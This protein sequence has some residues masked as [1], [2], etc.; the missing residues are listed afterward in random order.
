MIIGPASAS[1]RRSLLQ[2]HSFLFGIPS[3]AT[4]QS[5]FRWL[6][7]LRATQ[8]AGSCR[9]RG[10][11]SDEQTPWNEP[12]K[13]TALQTSNEY[14]KAADLFGSVEDPFESTWLFKAEEKSRRRKE[15]RLAVLLTGTPRQSSMLCCGR[16]SRTSASTTA[17]HMLRTQSVRLSSPSSACYFP[18]LKTHYKQTFT[19]EWALVDSETLKHTD[20][21]V[22]ADTQEKFRRYFFFHGVFIDLFSR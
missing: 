18:D 13:L 1:C 22:D 2:T 6:D 20:T 10:L 12:H 19:S 14:N 3:P 4:F 9:T 15:E 8:P 16:N 5:V 17:L 7:C 11:D 21:H